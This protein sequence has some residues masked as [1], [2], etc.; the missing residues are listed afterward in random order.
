VI[1]STSHNT[2]CYFSHCS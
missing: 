2:Y 1:T